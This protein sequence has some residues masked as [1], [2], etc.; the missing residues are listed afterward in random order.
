ELINRQWQ[1]QDLEDRVSWRAVD[2]ASWSPNRWWV[3]AR[4]QLT[5]ARTLASLDAG[6]RYVGG[7]P[8]GPAPWRNG[9]SRSRPG[10]SKLDWR[11]I[12]WS[13]LAAPAARRLRS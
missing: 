3:R 5:V 9:W 8:P 11:R 6:P 4:H 13:A 2:A 10:G 1:R 12:C 7:R